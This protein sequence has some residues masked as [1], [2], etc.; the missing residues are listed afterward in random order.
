MP[1]VPPIPF[2]LALIVSVL[3]AVAPQP[4]RAHSVQALDRSTGAPNSTVHKPL[5][6]SQTRERYERQDRRARPT[7]PP[8]QNYTNQPL[9]TTNTWESD[10]QTDTLAPIG[11]A[12]G[13]GMAYDLWAG[14]SVGQVEN[15]ITEL[16]IPPRSSTIHDLWA[17]IMTSKAEPPASG[18]TKVPFAAIQSEALYRSGL[19]DDAFAV[20]AA[21]SANANP[22]VLSETLKARAA[23][24]ANKPEAGCAI[25]RTLVRK[26]NKLPK[27]LT[28][29]AILMIGYCA[30]DA[31]NRAAA[32]LAADLATDNGLGRSAGVAALRAFSVNTGPRLKA[33]ATMTVMDF[34]IVERVGGRITRG[35]LTNAKP[36]LLT[37]VATSSKPPIDVRIAAGE[38]ALK[39]NAISLRDMTDIYRGTR[40]PTR[41]VAHYNAD[42]GSNFGDETRRAALY[43]AAESEQSPLRKARNIR[44]FLDSAR[45]AGLYWHGLKLMAD[46]ANQLALLPEIGWF[47]ETG[48]EVSLAAGDYTSARRW[49]TFAAA[50]RRDGGADLAHWQGLIDIA[51][52]SPAAQQR[53]HEGLVLIENATRR[54]LFGPVLLHRLAMVLDAL[55]IQVPIPLWEIASRTPQPTT[56]HLPKTGVLSALKDAAKHRQ[57]AH[58]VLLVMKTLGPK[59][60]EGAHMIALGDSIRALRR[61]GLKPE[62][63]QLGLEALFMS[64]PRAAR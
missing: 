31:N 33:K 22:T 4:L 19:L 47:A 45:R 60:A 64:W 20:F 9:P 27:S 2:S 34:R 50:Q 13:S 42:G 55:D 25:A 46:P 38:A 39:Y 29:T 18:S 15:L 1:H 14:L 11:A 7:Y 12:D 49:A 5:R 37:A 63:R 53:R 28:R 48:I 16:S 35:H 44:A 32:G 52:P 23:I 62:A 26:L 40:T 6:I 10:V 59:G 43:N 41:D 56:G 3:G 17:R 8:P 54:G 51:D 36:A 61:G 58:L 24:A 30:V 21:P 57:Q